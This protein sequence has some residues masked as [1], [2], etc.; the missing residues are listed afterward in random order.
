MRLPHPCPPHAQAFVESGKEQLR[1]ADVED[2]SVARARL[3]ARRLKR[4]LREKGAQAGSDDEQVRFAGG[5]V[6]TATPWS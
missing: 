2:K 6:H 4:K 1:E 5:N 3:R